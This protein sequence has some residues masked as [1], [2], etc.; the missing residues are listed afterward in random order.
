MV[1]HGVKIV[2]QGNLPSTLAT[3]ASELCQNLQNLLYHLSDK[4]GFKWELEEEI[5]QGTLIVHNG[6]IKK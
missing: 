6:N 4:D 3:N 5:T 2:G 1:K